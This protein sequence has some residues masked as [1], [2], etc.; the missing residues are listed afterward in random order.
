MFLRFVLVTPT[1]YLFTKRPE[2]LPI[3]PI[4]NWTRVIENAII[5]AST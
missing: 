4:D 3:T 1:K 5:V 2:M